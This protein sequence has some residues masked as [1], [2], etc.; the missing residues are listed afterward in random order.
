[1]ISAYT[2]RNEYVGNL[3]PQTEYSFD[4]PITDP[5]QIAIIVTDNLFNPIF[6]VRG[7]D[8]VNLTSVVINSN[9]GGFVN[10]AT[11]LPDNYFLTLL[12]ANDAPVQGT[13]FRAQGDF[14]LKTFEAVADYAIAAIQRLAYLASRSLRIGDNLQISQPFNNLIPV[15]STNPGVQNNVGLAL[16]IGSDNKSVTLAPQGSIGVPVQQAGVTPTSPVKGQ[17]AYNSVFILAVYTGTVW[18]KAADG[19]TPVVF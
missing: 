11:A 10:L 18:V 3:V 17:Q 15:N 7:T 5:S 14:T 6:S 12:L 16:V 13:T 19:T 9:G 2:P 8:T 4:F 1:M